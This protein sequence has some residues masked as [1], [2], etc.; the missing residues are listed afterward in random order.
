MGAE[1]PVWVGGFQKWV[2][3]VTKSTTCEDIVQAVLSSSPRSKEQKG[4]KDHKS[5]TIVERWRKVERPLEGKS[6]ILKVWKT[7]GEEQ[8]NVRFL[9]KRVHPHTYKDLRTTRRKTG[10]VIANNSR[11]KT[12]Y[13]KRTKSGDNTV[14]KSDYVDRIKKI[15]MS[16]EEKIRSQHQEL[17]DKDDEIEYYET[18]IH[19]VRME[20]RGVNYL[21]DTYLGE[22]SEEESGSQASVGGIEQTAHLYEKVLSLCERIDKEEENIKDLS[23]R[24]RLSVALGEENDEEE[25]KLNDDKKRLPLPDVTSC[26]NTKLSDDLLGIQNEITRLVTVNDTQ[27]TTIK[28]NED[29]IREYGQIIN[30]KYLHLHQLQL[31]LEREERETKILQEEL[32]IIQNS[33]VDSQPTCA[34]TSSEVPEIGDSNSDTGLSSLHSGSDDGACVLDTLV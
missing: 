23:S 14:C 33:H 7:W 19:I 20:E 11:Y 31:D 32:S 30:E 24:I 18:K 12:L 25:N 4:E 1:I 15:V 9:L 22:T 2:T 34:T 26:S 13:S 16:Q 10:K 17:Q 6:R 3:G 5:Y 8:C 29:T 27:R 21:I 28:Q